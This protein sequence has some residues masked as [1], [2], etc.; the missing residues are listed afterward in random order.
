MNAAQQFQLATINPVAYFTSTKSLINPGKTPYAPFLPTPEVGSAP[1]RAVT[2]AQLDA[3]PAGSAPPFDAHTFSLH[4]LQTLSPE[5][6]PKD[7]P[8]LTPGATELTNCT[9]DPAQPPTPCA[10]PDTRIRHFDRLPN[11][12]FQITGP[13]VP[14]DSYTGDMVHR[15]FHMW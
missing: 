3:N 14:Y 15:F 8:L 4:Q 1:P 13:T 5:I 10:E 9:T 6:A 2:L 12:S 11:T 7:L